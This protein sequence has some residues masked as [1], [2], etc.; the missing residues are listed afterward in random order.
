MNTHTRYIKQSSTTITF[1]SQYCMC[2]F[3]VCSRII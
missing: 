3:T 2:M 1:S